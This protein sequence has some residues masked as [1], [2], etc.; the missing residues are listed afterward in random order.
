MCSEKFRTECTVGERTVHVLLK[1]EIEGLEVILVH[2]EGV[3]VK[4]EL[5]KERDMGG[6]DQ[7]PNRHS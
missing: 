5:R 4:A 1:K 6:G 7:N 2:S 3:K